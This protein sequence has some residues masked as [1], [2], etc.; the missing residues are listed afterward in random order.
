MGRLG[1]IGMIDTAGPRLA[2]EWHLSSN[3]YPPVPHSMVGPCL[4]AIHN[5]NGGEWDAPVQ[6]PEGV[7]WRGQTSCP[8]VALIEGLHLADFLEGDDE[9]DPEP[10][11]DE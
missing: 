4:E 10:D 1:T 9:Y 8:T 3:H 11:D 6:L 2:L 5:A 7:Q